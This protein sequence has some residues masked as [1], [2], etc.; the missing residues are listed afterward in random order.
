MPRGRSSSDVNVDGSR[1]VGDYDKL[2]HTSAAEL[3]EELDNKIAQIRKK[4]MEY[5]QNGIRGSRIR[6]PEP[7]VN[8]YFD[9]NDIRLSGGLGMRRITSDY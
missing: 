3:S 7:R 9:E 2:R 5:T 4:Y 8:N 1:L 6:D